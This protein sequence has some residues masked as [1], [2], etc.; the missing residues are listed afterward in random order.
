VS[1]FLTH[2]HE[3]NVSTN[4]RILLVE[5]DED[6]VIMMSQLIQRILHHEVGVARDGLEAIRM[7]QSERYNLVLLDLVLPNLHG[8]D[9]ARSLRRMEAYRDV[10]II[11]LTAYDMQDVRERALEAGCDEVLSKPVGINRLI[12]LISDLLRPGPA[13]PG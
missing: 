1:A 10:P 13:E 7:A 4:Y 3:E 12:L 5:D 11:A 2:E 9:V 6:D 8:F